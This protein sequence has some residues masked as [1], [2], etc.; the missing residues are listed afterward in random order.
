MH[1]FFAVNYGKIVLESSHFNSNEPLVLKRQQEDDPIWNSHPF[2]NAASDIYWYRK[3]YTETLTGQ[4]MVLR[5]DEPALYHFERPKVRDSAKDVALVALIKAYRLLWIAVSLMVAIAFP[6]TKEIM[7][8]IA[9]LLLVDLLWR[10]WATRKVG[11][12]D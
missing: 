12:D 8:A 3:F 4:L 11:Q 6:W 7:S 5:T 1:I 10:C 9:S 2:F